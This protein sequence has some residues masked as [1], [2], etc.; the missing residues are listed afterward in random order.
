MSARTDSPSMSLDPEEYSIRSY[1][2]ETRRKFE[3][4]DR[5]PLKAFQIYSLECERLEVEL[6]SLKKRM[7]NVIVTPSPSKKRK[8]DFIENFVKRAKHCEDTNNP[9]PPLDV[10]LQMAY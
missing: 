6:Y 10:S 7:L 2:L 5:E 3:F 4:L 9:Q 1:H 8:S